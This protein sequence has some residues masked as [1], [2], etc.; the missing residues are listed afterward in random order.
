MVASLTELSLYTL[1]TVAVLVG[2]F[3]V[4]SPFT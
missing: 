4:K 1:T 2:M 3:Q